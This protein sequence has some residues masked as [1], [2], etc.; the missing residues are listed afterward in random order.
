MKKDIE[1]LKHVA[2][3]DSIDQAADKMHLSRSSVEKLLQRVKLSLNARTLTHAVYLATKQGF[4]VFLI[5][6][7]VT[8]PTGRI[9]RVTRR[10]TILTEKI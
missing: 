1:A 2:H 10:Q 6:V 9:S 7:V 5:A 3:G 4:I 8:T